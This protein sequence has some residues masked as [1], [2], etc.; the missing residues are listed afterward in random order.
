MSKRIIQI[1]IIIVIII[2]AQFGVCRE[3]IRFNEYLNQ[4]FEHNE[5]GGDGETGDKDLLEW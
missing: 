4:L 3:E 1:T 5:G 2:I